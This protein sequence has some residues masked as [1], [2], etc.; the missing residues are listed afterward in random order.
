M[1]GWALT[2]RCGKVHRME[3]PAG[4][5]SAHWGARKTQA[6]PTI[7]LPT[8]SSL[9]AFPP[10]DHGQSLLTRGVTGQ[11]LP[12]RGGFRFDL[13]FK[14]F[15]NHCLQLYPLVQFIS[16]SIQGFWRELQKTG[17]KE[18]EERRR[19]SKWSL[20]PLKVWRQGASWWCPD[21][22]Y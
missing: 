8:P 7:P 9:W 13:D 20:W 22:Q 19:N 17:P 12:R 5:V 15:L 14:I 4:P 18:V 16:A 21:A 1:E 10:G 2:V 11:F 6:A 3:D